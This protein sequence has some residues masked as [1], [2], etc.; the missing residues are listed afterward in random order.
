MET[1][2]KKVWKDLDHFSDLWGIGETQLENFFRPQSP[3]F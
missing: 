1:K 3:T 2:G